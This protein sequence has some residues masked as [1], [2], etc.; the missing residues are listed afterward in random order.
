MYSPC[1]IF[2]RKYLFKFFS[3]TNFS[4][5]VCIEKMTEGRRFR[6]P[7]NHGIKVSPGKSFGQRSQVN[8]RRVLTVLR[9]PRVNFQEGPFVDFSIF[10]FTW[11]QDPAYL[12]ISKHMKNNRMICFMSI[13]TEKHYT[14][15]PKPFCLWSIIY[16]TNFLRVGVSSKKWSFT[17]H[18]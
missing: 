12:K 4:V 8:F 2:S 17:K 3:C 6:L 1:L 10:P 5:I 7:V 15:F 18:C 9:A 16:F 13:A 11:T 14:F